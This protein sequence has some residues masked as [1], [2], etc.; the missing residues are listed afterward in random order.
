M[1]TKIIAPAIKIGP[2]PMTIPSI[3]RQITPTVIMIRSLIENRVPNTVILE[4]RL[5]LIEQNCIKF[6]HHV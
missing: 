3:A 4:Y 2:N 6:L 1:M 5:V